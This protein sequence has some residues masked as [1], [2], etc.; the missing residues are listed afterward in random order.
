[1]SNTNSLLKHIIFQIILTILIF[2]IL[3]FFNFNNVI[4]HNA[5]IIFFLLFT[6]YLSRIL[7]KSNKRINLSVRLIFNLFLL[8]ESFKYVEFKMGF[9]PHYNEVPII[10]AVFSFLII[11]IYVVALNLICRCIYYFEN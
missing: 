10:S 4:T 6:I 2:S 3:H 1:M 7:Y 11:V 8:F 5:I 9:L